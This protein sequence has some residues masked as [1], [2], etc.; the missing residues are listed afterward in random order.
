MCYKKPRGMGR[1]MAAAR[2]GKNGRAPDFTVHK[3]D[4]VTEI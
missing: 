2:K 3:T 1:D 4:S